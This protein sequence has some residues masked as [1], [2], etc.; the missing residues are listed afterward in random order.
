MASLT[1]IVAGIL[2]AACGGGQTG[3]PGASPTPG[4]SPTASPSPSP[5]VVVPI[6]GETSA[7][8][9]QAEI[10]LVSRQVEVDGTGWLRLDGRLANRG[11]RSATAIGL[12]A[13]LYDGSGILLDTR[14]AIVTPS[15]LAPSQEAT[16]ALVWPPQGKVDVITLQPRWALATPPP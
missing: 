16:F 15:A 13:R 8:G 2:L 5:P 7:D 3:S 11:T 4:P 14:E 1:G 10:V 6:E 12:R 9:W